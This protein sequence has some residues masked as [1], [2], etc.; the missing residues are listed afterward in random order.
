LYFGAL[1][2]PGGF[3]TADV[4]SALQKSIRRGHEKEA[5]F[6]ATELELAGFGEYLWNRLRIINSEDVGVGDPLA[7]L[8]VRAL[9][10]NWEQRV[11]KEKAAAKGGRELPPESRLYLLHAVQV[12]CR[13][14]K[15]RMVDHAYMTYYEG[16]RAGL[17]IEIPD[18][19]LDGHTYRGKKAGRGPEFFLDESSK[20]ENEAMVEDL[21]R[22]TGRKAHLAHFATEHARERAFRAA[23]AEGDEFEKV[24][25]KAA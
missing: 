16:D 8:Q 22:E 13:A 19:A 4:T 18:Y 1:K 3:V 5:L 14:Q 23:N 11:K 9:Y 24:A 17:G 6:W 10:E 7:T 15:S 2:T 12:L 21:Y 20:L 25:A